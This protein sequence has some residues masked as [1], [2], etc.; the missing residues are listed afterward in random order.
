VP[1]AVGLPEH[2]TEESDAE[3][4]DAKGEAIRPGVDAVWNQKNP[5]LA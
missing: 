3:K 2:Q 4:H 1:H 5:W